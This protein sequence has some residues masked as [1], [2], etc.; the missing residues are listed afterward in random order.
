MVTGESYKQILNNISE[1]I[2]AFDKDFII[3][4]I[5]RPA[6]QLLHCK[7]NE[8]IGTCITN[9]LFLGPALSD[10]YLL[11][12]LPNEGE[13]TWTSVIPHLELCILIKTLFTGKEFN[14]GMVTLTPALNSA[15]G[16]QI[17]GYEHEN[18]LLL[19]ETIF[20][21]TNDSILVTDA[22]LE[23]P[24]PKILF[25][26]PAFTQMT[27]Y[28]IEEVY[29]KTPRIL[30]GP[31]TNKEE[32]KRLKDTLLK[33]ENFSGEAINY[34]KDGT[35]FFIEW[36]VAPIRNEKGDITHFTAVQRDITEKKKTLNA[37]ST[38]LQQLQSHVDNSPLAIL[39]IDKNLKLESWSLRA[40]QLFGWKS[41]EVLGRTKD[42]LK[43]IVE[44]D[45]PEMLRVMDRLLSKKE[46]R[47]VA[48]IRNYTKSGTIIFCEW[49]NT[50]L[51]DDNGNLISI[52]SLVN[53]VTVKKLEEEALNKGQE[54]ERQRIA[55]EIHD[56]IGQMLV[57][58]KF[59]VGSL[60]VV[61]GKKLK[62]K[63]AEIEDLLDK[64]IEEARRTSQNLAPRS[65]TDFG[66]ET[67]IRKL[68]EQTRKL[69]G[70]NVV[71]YYIGEESTPENKILVALYRI[72]QE[73]LNNIVK[74][75]HA[76]RVKIQ[77]FISD[78][79]IEL[80]ID[81]NG[82]GFNIDTVV[83]GNGLKNMQE[84]TKIENGRFQIDS[85]EGKGTR[86]IVNIPINGFVNSFMINGEN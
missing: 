12:K 47:N 84:R 35:E 13:K 44:E 67:A 10:I 71:F 82:K 14:G 19:F 33:G 21:Q 7:E 9:H 43:F 29:G 17:L 81:D 20:R 85:A 1:S 3:Y 8:L 32:L 46:T 56:G 11:I 80:K 62:E 49:Y 54:M 23:Y 60:E 15:K 83:R 2:I 72:T 36:E 51:F 75:A 50:A 30:Q 4:F 6:C 34:K 18:A 45:K 59:N 79:N 37:L 27:G 52:F 38:A 26:N 63:A 65:L 28:P 73:A 53:D 41:E 22:Q 57:A 39:Q 48:F 77:I 74:Y 55:R 40:E 68:C 61:K 78:R 69:T 31:K 70:I 86:L 66:I 58:I 76:T 42:E 25:A 16:K 24:G 64:T 5:N